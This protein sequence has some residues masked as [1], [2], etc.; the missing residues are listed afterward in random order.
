MYKKILLPAVLCSLCFGTFATAQA[1][2]KVQ[3]I[4]DSKRYEQ[5]CKGKRA[6]Q[7]VSFAHRGIIWNGSCQTQFL[8]SNSMAVMGNEPE[9]YTAC[10]NGY[11][12]S[13][14][15][16]GRSLAGKCALAFTPPMPRPGYN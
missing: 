12:N 9:L 3:R 4:Y 16:N 15:I 10:A 6:G 11:T 14:M 5:V 2:D 1:N 7:W 13:A 8:P